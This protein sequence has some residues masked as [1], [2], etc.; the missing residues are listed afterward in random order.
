MHF[1][2]KGVEF[3]VWAGGVDLDIMECHNSTCT[4]YFF[5]GVE[6]IV[7]DRGDRS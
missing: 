6:F 7:Y 2:C 4:G 5:K 3:I 1:F